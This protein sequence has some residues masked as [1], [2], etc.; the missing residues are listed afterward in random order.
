MQG[1]QGRSKE[2]WDQSSSQHLARANGTG[3]HVPRRSSERMRLNHPPAT[4]R[5]AR[6]RR[7]EPPST[8]WRRRLII[9]AFIFVVCSLLACGIG[10]AAVNLLQGTNASAGP[11]ITVSDFLKNVNIRDYDQAYNDL[12]AAITIQTSLGD[13]K[14][15]AQKDD[16]CYGP[17]ID[18]SEVSGSATGEG[19][20][21]SY[22]YTITRSKL[23]PPYQLRITL[24]QDTHGDW[25][26]S[27]YGTNNDLGPG[28]PPCS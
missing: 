17:V 21:Q 14:Q 11:A 15:Q 7:K 27:S 23:S 8:N 24:L 10:Y 13:F 22:T 4:R 5:V 2:P 18:Y 9:W 28:Q 19:K 25:R 26:I 3:K 12:D 16:R 1:R 6:P 20:T